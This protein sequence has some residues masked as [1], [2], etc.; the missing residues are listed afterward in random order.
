MARVA[1][2]P[3]PQGGQ[4]TTFI[5]GG[6]HG[7]AGAHGFARTSCLHPPPRGSRK[8]RSKLGA[9]PRPARA[10]RF[11]SPSH[12]Q[13]RKG[14]RWGA[15]APSRVRL[16]RLHPWSPPAM[17]R[18]ALLFLSKPTRLRTWAAEELTAEEG[19]EAVEE[20]RRARRNDRMPARL[21]GRW[22]CHPGR[23]PSV[24]CTRASALAAREATQGQN[25][26][27]FSQLPYKCYLE[28]VASVGD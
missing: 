28:E 13:V 23:L 8:L 17:P 20:A 1:L 21:H 6:A 3:A 7:L 2:R 26:S 4:V 19:M 14:G 15:G 10:L 24:D 22:C 18:A 16:S 12:L 11:V 27:F 9:P 25:D 5:P